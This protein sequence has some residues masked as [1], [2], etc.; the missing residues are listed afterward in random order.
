M[1]R[2]RVRPTLSCSAP[3]SEPVLFGLRLKIPVRSAKG[4]CHNFRSKLCRCLHRG[5]VSIARKIL[6]ALLIVLVMGGGVARLLLW[7][8]WKAESR[9]SSIRQFEKADH[10]HPPPPG[11][12]VFM[13]SSSIRLWDTL[14]EDM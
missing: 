14:V 6:V 11:V 5:F 9:E 10:L 7:R 3:V 4:T 8:M 1:N 12:I 2:R 13:G